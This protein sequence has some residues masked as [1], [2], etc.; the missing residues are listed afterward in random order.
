V[1]L[2]AIFFGWLDTACAALQTYLNTPFPALQAI[3]GAILIAMLILMSDRFRRRR[4]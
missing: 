4:I 1:V 3:Q 2:A